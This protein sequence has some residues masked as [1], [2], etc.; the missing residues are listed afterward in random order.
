MYVMKVLEHEIMSI[1]LAR[2]EFLSKKFNF[3][4]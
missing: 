2:A 3:K 1:D 4:Q